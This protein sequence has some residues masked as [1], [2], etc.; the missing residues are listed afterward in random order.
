MGVTLFINQ[1]NFLKMNKKSGW[2][3]YT[4]CFTENYANFEGRARRSE[5]WYFVLFNALI[6]YASMFVFGL[7]GGMLDVPILAGIG[8]VY[9]FAALIPG[10]AVA[11]RRLHDTNKSGWM[12]LIGLIP[13]VGSIVLIVFFATEGTQ[14]SNEYGSDPKLSNDPFDE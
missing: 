10:L 14:G 13:V 1:L 7:I 12:I 9:V 8:F 3:Y 2:E 4:S 11:I 6:G 5:Y